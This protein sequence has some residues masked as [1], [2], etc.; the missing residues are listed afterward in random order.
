M[1]M[2]S[3]ARLRLRMGVLTERLSVTAREGGGERWVAHFSSFQ[4]A[5]F[6]PELAGLEM[7]G[8]LRARKRSSS[9][10]CFSL[11]LGCEGAR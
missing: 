9:S 8:L 4:V 10:R 2:I 11:E 7:G 3:M 1:A 5:S 6:S